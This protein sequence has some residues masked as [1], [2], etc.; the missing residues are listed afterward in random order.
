MVGGVLDKK[1][2]IGVIPAR[3][4]SSRFPGKPL[5]DIHGKPMIYWVAKRVEESIIEEYYVATDDIRIMD[6]CNKYSLPCIMT[7]KNCLNGTERV[8]E[9]STK[10]EA[11]YFVNI[12]GDEPAINVEAINKIVM[13]LNKHKNAV[14]IQAITK[15][16]EQHRIL[17]DSLVKVAVSDHSEVLFYSRLPIPFR[18]NKNSLIK[19]YHFRCLGLYLYSKDL[20][21][22]YLK[23]TPTTLEKIE[24]IEQL[25]LIENRII[26]NAE[27]VND[28]G[29]SVD[30]PEDLIIIREQY[31]DCFVK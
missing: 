28:D 30:T 23:M 17:D 27:E 13:S 31:K 7:S 12:Q 24:N 19:P 26:I 15:L 2:I 5:V 10:I 16:T 11:D 18:Q 20:L 9:V 4:E 25:R 29:I 22:R 3:Y 21:S 14:Y 6:A 8:A 1:K